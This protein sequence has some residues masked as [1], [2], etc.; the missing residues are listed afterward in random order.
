MT[1]CSV[2]RF[3]HIRK[4]LYT[5]KGRISLAVWVPN[6]VSQKKIENEVDSLFI[7]SESQTDCCLDIALVFENAV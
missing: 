2:D 1:Q 6:D 3:P 5:W 7:Y 4:Q